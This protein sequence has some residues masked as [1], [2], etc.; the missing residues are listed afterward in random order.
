MVNP[1]LGGRGGGEVCV[2][3]GMKYLLRFKETIQEVISYEV[4]SLIGLESI[5]PSPMHGHEI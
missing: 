3:N 2:L 4:L 5:G 1:M